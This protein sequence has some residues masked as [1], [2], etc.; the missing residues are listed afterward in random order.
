MNKAEL[1]KIKN[2]VKQMT[3]SEKARICSGADFWHTEAIPRLNIPSV[4]MAD[5]PHGLRREVK[6]EGGNMSESYPSTCFPSSS[7]LACS[8]D[9]ELVKEV[10][11][12]IAREAASRDVSIVLGPGINIK[13]SPLCGRNF[14]YF[15]EDPCLAG[16]LGAAWVQGAQSQGVGACVKHFAAN[17]QENRRFIS[18]SC[19]DRRALEEI[20][21]EAFRRVVQ[22][23]PCSLMTSYN[24]LNN[25]YVAESGF[26]IEKKLRGEWGFDGMVISDW[27]AVND[28]VAAI[29]AGL[30][31]EMPGKTSDTAYDII[32][33]VRAKRLPR[34]QLDDAVTRILYTV[35]ECENERVT[36]APVDYKAHD[37]LARRAAVESIVLLKNEGYLLP[38]DDGKPFAVIGHYAEQ[39]RYQGTGSS[40]I[41][42]TSLPTVVQEL[43]RR[44]LDYTYCE[45][46]NAD[47]STN[48]MLIAQARQAVEQAG[49]GVIF[50]ALP[51]IYESEGFDRENMRFPDGILKLIDQLA[52]ACDNLAVVLMLG[53]P[54]ELPFESRIKS[55]MTCYLGGQAIA[56]AVVDV[57]TGRMTPGGKLAESWPRRLADTPCSNYFNKGKKNAEYREG[58]FVGYRYY[59]AAEID[60]MFSFGHGLSYTSFL[61]DRLSL[62]R[63]TISERGRINLS[64]RIK[65]TGKRQGAETV[66]IYTAK[67][68]GKYKQLKEFKKIFLFPGENRIL[69]FTLSARDFSYFN[70]N[71]ERFELESG[72]YS[73]LIG[74]GSRDIRLSADISADSRRNRAVPEYFEPK[75]ANNLPDNIFYPLLGYLPTEPGWKPL[76][77]NSTLFELS[78]TVEGRLI[79]RSVRNAYFAS[80]PKNI[81]S[82]TRRMFERSLEDLPLRALCAL[83]GG[84]LTKNTAIALVHFANHRLLR[85]VYRLMYKRS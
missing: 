7:L 85:G 53:S 67:K 16:E 2:I 56:P 42:P 75:Q 35:K 81:D 10:G 62:D 45:G 28:R 9:R 34:E 8:F 57:I 52:S 49:R 61:Y 50:A 13:R 11:S 17:N 14:E 21:L 15:S 69:N 83:S 74:S 43:G 6:N 65:N 22:A 77:L 12:A 48:D 20:Y 51:D 84:A 4:T 70:T 24:M 58:I 60:P 18:N 71:T 46:C 59:D 19:V 37:M 29:R 80:I 68:D 40:K 38:F 26:L 31:L 82:A 54:A 64:V 73:V 79:A 30:D 32:S 25:E 27:G 76:T 36:G 47:G 1:T 39:I 78:H 66:Q 5:G 23:G 3:L 72:E 41:N 55:L 63:K 33:A 44:G